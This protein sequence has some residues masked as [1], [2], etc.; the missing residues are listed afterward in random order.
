M[1]H[2]PRIISLEQR[3]RHPVYDVPDRK[4]LQQVLQDTN[5]K[6]GEKLGENKNN[7]FHKIKLSQPE[8]EDLMLRMT[9]ANISKKHNIPTFISASIM[10]RNETSRFQG[11]DVSPREMKI[12]C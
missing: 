2:F 5:I 7:K 1:L 3:Y 12:Q 6:R 10:L 9:T 8:V 4:S 11:N